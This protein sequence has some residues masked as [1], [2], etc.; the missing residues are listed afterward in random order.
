MSVWYAFHGSVEVRLT[1]EV[2][3]IVGEFNALAHEIS[4]DVDDHGDGTATVEFGGGDFCSYA[5]AGEIDAKAQELGPHATTP[6]SLIYD[7]DGERG[8]LPIGPQAD[9]LRPANWI[10]RKLIAERELTRLHG[11]Q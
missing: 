3:R 8:E 10:Q 1:P 7:C 9:G 6:A 2:E 11:R 5:T 4:A